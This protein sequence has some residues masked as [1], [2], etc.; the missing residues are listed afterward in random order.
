M[1]VDI[2]LGIVL[3]VIILALLPFLVGIG[4]AVAAIGLCVGAVA[5]LVL[6]AKGQDASTLLAWAAGIGAVVGLSVLAVWQEHWTGVAP[7]DV[8]WGAIAAGL[9]LLLA[10][11]GA[12][13][14]IIRGDTDLLATYCVVWALSAIVLFAFGRDIA[15]TVRRH[16]AK[17]AD[18]ERAKRES[19]LDAYHR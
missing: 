1:A 12:Y 11:H 3:A 7:M 4:I 16:R 10:A 19:E 6:W 14:V 18:A 15:R 2:A 17:L 13:E 9:I 5:L 8:F